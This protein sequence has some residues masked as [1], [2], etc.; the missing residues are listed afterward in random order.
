MGSSGTSGSGPKARVSSVR[1]Y[2]P[3]CS[4]SSAFFFFWAGFATSRNSATPG[5]TS[6]Q[7]SRGS[8]RM[9]IVTHPATTSSTPSSI[10][11]LSVA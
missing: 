4:C 5:N 6:A 3:S 7:I 10:P 9:N 11:M 8:R 2:P 1:K